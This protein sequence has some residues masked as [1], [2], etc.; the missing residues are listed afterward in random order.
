[1]QAGRLRQRVRIEQAT[2]TRDAFGA[3]LQSWGELATVWADVLPQ[4]GGLGGGGGKETFASDGA[5][6]RAY[7]VYTISVRWRGDLTSP[8]LRAVW[9][10]KFLDIESMVD[11][12]GRKRILTLNCRE[13]R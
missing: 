12:D 7:Q 13:R 11:P 10:G 6:E 1:M 3:T 2:E 5:V 9:G 4:V 8:K